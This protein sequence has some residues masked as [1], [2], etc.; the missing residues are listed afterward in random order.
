MQY[1]EQKK[2][3]INGIPSNYLCNIHS[4]PCAGVAFP[5]HFHNYI[6]VLY[7]LE[8]QFHVLLNGKYHFFAK[9]DLILINSRE[10]HHINAL[11]ESGGSYIVL[12]FEPEV[13]YNNMF[14]NYSELKYTIP[15][16]IDSP[17]QQK[18]ITK[19]LLNNTNIPEL[20]WDILKEMEEQCYGFELAVRNHIGRIFLWILRYFHANSS[21]S[22]F[23]FNEYELYLKRLQP[24]LDYVPNN[25]MNEIKTP[26]MASLCNMSSSYFSRLFNKVMNMNFNDYINH[27]RLKEAEKLLVSTELNITE[28]SNQVGFNTTSYFIKLF[29]QNKGTSPKQ[30]QKEYLH[31]YESND[32][33]I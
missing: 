11:S 14:Q 6:E 17:N 4:V 19:D 32:K 5:A 26:D 15:F 23:Q 29:K 16:L 8:G 12:R 31:D 18:V 2:E 7:G 9:G 25:Y 24:A 27:I 33:P 21:N 10:V 28:I 22:I 13:I 1:P 20:L 3:L 30:Y